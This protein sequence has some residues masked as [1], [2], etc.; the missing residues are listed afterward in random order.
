MSLSFELI[1]KIL[2]NKDKDIIIQ[3]IV[4]EFNEKKCLICHDNIKI[5]VTLNSYIF[6]EE[7]GDSKLSMV[8]L[9][10]ARS[11]LQLN[12]TKVNRSNNI[13]HLI[14]QK[15]INPKNLNAKY[16][17]YIENELIDILDKYPQQK[18]ICSCNKV[19]YLHNE[20]YNHKKNGTCSNSYFKCPFCGFYGKSYEFIQHMSK[21][22]CNKM[23][24]AHNLIFKK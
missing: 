24:L 10:C 19:F 3:K 17:Y 9:D 18:L 20:L 23:K 22:S 15:N 8:C 2:S 11:Y 1:D 13:K 14:C 16:S 21:L 12:I 4:N 5:P 7:C 6:C